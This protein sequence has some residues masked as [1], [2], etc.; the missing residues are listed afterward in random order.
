L[1]FGTDASGAISCRCTARTSR[2]APLPTSA[3]LWPRLNELFSII[4]QGSPSLKVA[5]FD[6]GFFD[7]ERH[8]FLERHTVGEVHLQQAFDKLV[9]VEGLFADYRDCPLISQ[10]AEK[11]NLSN[12][13]EKAGV[14]GRQAPR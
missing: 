7:P 1:H 9:C 13:S 6:G 5:T 11:D 14:I 8:S 10:Y 3:T 12:N 2:S 4:K